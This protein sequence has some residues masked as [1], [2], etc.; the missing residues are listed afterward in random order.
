[1]QL[2]RVQVEVRALQIVEAVL[3][4]GRVE[5]D[6]VE[7]KGDWPT[8]RHVRQ[9]AAHANAARGEPII[10]L[11]GVD[12]KTHQVTRP[13]DI[14][15]AD[16]WAAISKRFDEVFPEL[17]HVTLHI[18]AAKTV[19]ALAFTTDQAP[20]VITT[21]ADEGRVEREVPIRVATGTRSAHRHDLL[22]MLA[23]AMTVPQ[24]FPIEVDLTTFQ[25]FE[26]E[27]SPL[28]LNAKVFFQHTEAG[29]VMLPAHRMWGRIDFGTRRTA[30]ELPPIDMAMKHDPD[31][32]SSASVK[33]H[34]VV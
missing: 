27:Y 7:C 17:L 31:E 8:E 24:A 10:W 21:G 12:E 6:L 5:D 28:S 34:D 2:R 15:P 22:R 20:Y 1:M 3:A 14:D 30:S 23:P 18:D 13:R 29:S 25:F 19:T 32:T 16:W 33:S 9:L 4:G 11:I 26:D